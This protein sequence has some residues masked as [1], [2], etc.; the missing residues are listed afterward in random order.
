MENKKSKEIESLNRKLKKAFKTIELQS[1]RIAELEEF[2][3]SFDLDI[4]T[5]SDYF[6]EDVDTFQLLP[7]KPIN[8]INSFNEKDIIV[9]APRNIVAIASSEDKRRKNIYV[10]EQVKS[11]EAVVEYKLT[12]RDGFEKLVKYFDKFNWHLV[13]VSQDAVFNVGYYEFAGNNKIVSNER[14]QLPNTI[15]KTTTLDSS[16]GR[17]FRANFVKVKSM[18]LE[19]TI[20]QK[21]I[22]SVREVFSRK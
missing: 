7:P 21:K 13:R 14:I 22:E 5:M 4:L 6:Q 17:K 18:Y 1:K 10:I 19:K 3:R 8:V 2:E 20:L 15:K 9:V 12:T 16:E 11:K